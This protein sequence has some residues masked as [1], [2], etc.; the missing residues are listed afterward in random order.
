[1]ALTKTKRETLKLVFFCLSLSLLFPFSEGD[2]E[3]S[4]Y[5]VLQRY[6]LPIGLLPNG[7]FGYTLDPNSGRFPVNLSSNC[8]FHVG[9][10]EINYSPPITGVISQNNLGEI[11]GVKVKVLFF[12]IN[13]VNV[14]RNQ[15]QLR[16]NVGG[17]VNKDFPVND[18]N[19]CPKCK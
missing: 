17:L 15:D 1:M 18:F 5:Q 13:I 2:G 9:G 19:L 12:W 11:G 10:Y 4:A 6:N 7:A 14:N 8:N 3:Q 16:F